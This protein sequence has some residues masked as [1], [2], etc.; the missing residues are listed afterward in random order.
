MNF[1][2]FLKNFKRKCAV[3]VHRDAKVEI[4]DIIFYSLKDNHL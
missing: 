1:H 2:A 4:I 3:S